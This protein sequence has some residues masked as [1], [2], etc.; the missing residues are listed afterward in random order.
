MGLNFVRQDNYRGY[1]P[2][3]NVK[4][5]HVGKRLI[6]IITALVL[7]A[8][9]GYSLYKHFSPKGKMVTPIVTEAPDTNLYPTVP[10]VVETAI[11]T[12]TPTVAPTATPEPVPAVV[13]YDD[14][15]NR[16]DTVIATS[17]VN[18]RLN[19]TQKSNKLGQLPEGSV[20]N[21]ILSDG[22]WDL[23]QYGDQIA[24][25]HTKYTKE[26]EVDYNHEYYRMEEYSD[27]ART[28]SSLHFRL[29]PSK[30]E[31]SLCLLDK[32][33]EVVVI[34]KAIPFDNPKDV[35]LLVRARG[36]IGYVNAGYTKSLRS[37]LESSGIPMNEV[38]IQKYGYLKNSTTV[39][40]EAGNPYKTLDQYEL[41]EVLQKY[42]EYS[43][44][45]SNG[46]VGFVPNSSIGKING[47]FVTVD[48]SSQRVCYYV[49]NDL[50][51]KGRCTTGKNNS[52]TDLGFFTTGHKHNYH[53]FGHDGYE[54]VILWMAFNGG[55]GF[56]DAGWEADK[57]FGDTSYYKSHGSSGCVRLP[58]DVARYFYDHVNEGDGVLV[59]K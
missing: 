26:S 32:G 31:K 22:D 11:P 51:F 47:S 42:G 5:V 38:K 36:Q 58:N 1:Y 10:P 8:V 14:G 48:I 28:T 2:H 15:Y 23:I 40:N 7:G 25:V 43:L 35:W 44:I 56:H 41:V 19:A 16:G 46:V 49:N 53:D 21:R 33:E 12:A 57:K 13:S 17:D 39:L 59:K 9:G 50:A 37:V 20:V 29:G 45:H 55:E 4:K 18:L 27:I 34:G 6:A 3:N 52:P 30:D 54:A 24:Y